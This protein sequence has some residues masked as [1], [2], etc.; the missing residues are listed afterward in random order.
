MLS[1][2]S[3]TIIVAAAVGILT[4][5]INS[6]FLNR[7][8][9]NSRE[10]DRLDRI[11]ATKL[12]LAAGEER[13]ARVIKK[14]EEGIEKSTEAVNTSNGIKV[15]VANK[16]DRIIENKMPQEVIVKND[17]HHPVPTEDINS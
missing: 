12:T 16:L 7:N 10:Q 8:M 2:E 13:V 11:A 1:P 4:L 6:Y 3:I 17:V 9:V 5:F 15:E 14:V